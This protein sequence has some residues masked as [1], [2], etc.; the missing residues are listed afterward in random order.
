MGSDS[1]GGHQSAVFAS[2]RH[3]R[4]QLFRYKLLIRFLIYKRHA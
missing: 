3:I 2:R 4:P 1:V